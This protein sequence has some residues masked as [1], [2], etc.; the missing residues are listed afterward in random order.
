MK[1]PEDIHHEFAAAAS[2]GDIDRLLRL[3]E[4][5]AVVISP[6]GEHRA[7]ERREGLDAIR[8]HL[9]SL[10]GMRPQME[11]QASQAH[12]K[13]DLALLSSR[14]RATVTLPDGASTE[15]SGHGSELARRQPDGTWRLVID[16]PGGA[17]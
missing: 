9:T 17:G 8:E 10:L 7:G 1:N 6:P 12:R 14:W 11:I 2:A 3:Y 16:N 5:D 13:D 4:P 15:L